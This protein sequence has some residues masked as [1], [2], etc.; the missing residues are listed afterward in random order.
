MIHF[1]TEGHQCPSVKK[2]NFS[3]KLYTIIFKNYIMNSITPINS[4]LDIQESFFKESKKENPSLVFNAYV[5]QSGTKYITINI[6]ENNLDSDDFNLWLDVDIF[7]AELFAKKIL[8]LVAD[9]KSYMNKFLE[10][11][12]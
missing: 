3:A 11:N 6:C 4:A 8:K 5:E 9:R 7:Q 10:V 1:S 12:E 2:Y